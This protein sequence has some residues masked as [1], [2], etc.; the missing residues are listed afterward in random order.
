MRLQAEKA[1]VYSGILHLSKVHH[2]LLVLLQ[3]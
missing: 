1:D 3:S 2:P